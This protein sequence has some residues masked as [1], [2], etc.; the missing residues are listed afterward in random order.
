KPG[1]NERRRAGRIRGARRQHILDAAIDVLEASEP[2]AEVHVRQIADR[3][4]LSR[5][6][7]YRHFADRADLDAAVQARALELLRAELV[8]QLAFEGTPREIIR[9]IVSAYVGWASEHPSLHEFAQQNPP[10]PGAGQLERAVQQL[11]AQLEDLLN[12]GVELFH[13][14]LDEDEVAALDP[15]VFGLVGGVFT[16][17]RRWLSR[18]VQRPAR[19]TFVELV[20]EAV[21]QQIA[22]LTHSRAVALDPDLPVERLLE[23]ALDLDEV[24]G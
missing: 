14:Q 4:G 6:V 7:V 17:T 22:G 15:L 9:R 1:R 3:A 18:P 10:G 8:P 11:A 19:D 2:G 5:T 24:I 21:W 13:V 16:A 12:V 20:T 23:G